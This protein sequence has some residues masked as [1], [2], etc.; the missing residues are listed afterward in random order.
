MKHEQDK[1]PVLPVVGQFIKVP[2]YMCGKHYDDL[3]APVE[4]FRG[5]LGI[6]RSHNHRR[7]GVFLPLCELYVNGP[8]SKQDYIPNFGEY[9]TNQ[10][11]T[12]TIVA[13]PGNVGPD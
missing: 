11:P 1:E 2:L 7:A 3:I 9:W 10:I 5:C 13:G 8:D 4:M 12:W 6:F